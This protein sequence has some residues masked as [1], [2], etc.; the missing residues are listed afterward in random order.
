MKEL[1]ERAKELIENGLY[2]SAQAALSEALVI[3][4]EEKAELDATVNNL[5]EQ[6]NGV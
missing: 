1:I 2:E 6:L 5:L 3:Y 4:Q